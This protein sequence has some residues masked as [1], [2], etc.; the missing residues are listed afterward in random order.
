[1]ETSSV[2]SSKVGSYEIVYSFE[3]E[4]YAKKAY[5]YDTPQF[6]MNGGAVT[7]NRSLTYTEANAL[8]M[9][10]AEALG[11]TAKDSFGMNLKVDVSF[12]RAYLG[13]CGEYTFFYQ[14]IDAAENISKISVVYT[15]T[16]EDKKLDSV[17]ADITDERFSVAVDLR[18]SVIEEIVFD[19]LYLEEQFY[20]VFEEEIRFN[21]VIFEELGLCYKEE[22]D[23]LI[24]TKEWSAKCVLQRTDSAPII[25]ADFP[26]YNYIFLENEKIVLPM[27][28]RINQQGYQL[29]YSM[30][31]GVLTYDEYTNTAIVTSANGERL[32]KGKYYITATATQNGKASVEKKT[33]FQICGEEDYARMLAPLNGQF[34]DNIHAR[35]TNWASFTY[36]KAKNAFKRGVVWN[37]GDNHSMLAIP[38]SG[39]ILSKWIEGFGKYPYVALELCFDGVM[40]EDFDNFTFYFN[41]GYEGTRYKITDS[42]I[43]IYD[44]D[45]YAV[46]AAELKSNTWYDVYVPS[47]SK[48][49]DYNTW[50]F[51]FMTQ[52]STVRGTSPGVFAGQPVPGYVYTDYWVRNVRFD[53]VTE[54]VT[55]QN[56]YIYEES[57]MAGL[58][59]KSATAYTL[60]KAPQGVTLDGNRISSLKI[61][62]YTAVG[63]TTVSFRVYTATEYDKIIAPLT[64]TQFVDSFATRNNTWATFAYDPTENAYKHHATMTDP[65]TT[66]YVDNHMVTVFSGA[67]VEKI[68]ANVANKK[69]GYIALDLKYNGTMGTDFKSFEF[70][71][72]GTRTGFKSITDSSIK[73]CNQNGQIINAS[74]MQEGEWY[75]IYMLAPTTFTAD[76]SVYFFIKQTAKTAGVYQDY[77]VRNVRF[78]TELPTA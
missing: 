46:S 27:I 45:G 6:S 54:T 39:N 43:K 31:G 66:S 18:D 14:A 77:W 75:T 1:M 41:G 29:T 44:M 37:E 17:S 48:P 67:A 70:S 11:I 40:G 30:E 22:Y 26:F 57:N 20:E 7:T 56:G 63:D 9:L 68:N 4:Q 72:T 62:E 36:D 24:K 76:L 5:V 50:G 8:N 3:G 12:D 60:T 51:Y 13:E 28:E 78:A 53:N 42:A 55:L 35:N 47:V 25:C 71:S 16:G 69:Y 61:G 34:E 10:S 52:N 58:L 21:T 2:D 23:I 19:G 74:E 32:P 49:A 33:M 65:K 38:N 64:S 59:P 15:I 73:V